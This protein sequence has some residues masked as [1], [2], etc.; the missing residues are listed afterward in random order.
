[1]RTIFEQIEPRFLL[2]FKLMYGTGIRLME[3]CQ[4]RLKDIDFGLK[5]VI[6]HGGKGNRDRRTM[7]PDSL[8]DALREQVRF[9]QAQFDRDMRQ[10]KWAGATVEPALQRKFPGIARE[11]KWQY[12]FPARRF[13]KTKNA[14]GILLRH[15]LHET[16]L[17]KHIRL[18]SKSFPKRVSCH[19]FRHS[20][21]THLLEAGYDLRTV[22]ELLG[23]S[24]VKTTMIYTHVLQKGVP[25][26]SPMDMI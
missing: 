3:L 5:M 9:V 4:L 22:Q 1:V 17:Q 15:H 6:V 10:P 21:A 13:V 20:Y 8:A 7:L 18:I 14:N 16:V 26:K 2:H 23:H 25:V 12:L 11:L 19:T 24:D